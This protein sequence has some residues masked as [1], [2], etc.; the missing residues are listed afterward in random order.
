MEEMLN[1]ILPSDS[2]ETV[3]NLIFTTFDK[4]HNGNLNFVE[5]VTSLH[6]MSSSSPEVLTLSVY[7]SP[8]L[9]VCLSVS[10]SPCLSVCLPVCLPLS[11]SLCLSVCLSLSLRLRTS[12]TGCSSCTTVTAQAP[13]HCLRWCCCLPLSTR[14]RGSTTTWPW[15]ELRRYSVTSILTMTETSRRKSL[16]EDAYG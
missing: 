8:C 4:D 15:R 10:L 14:T 12:C 16:S 7:L 2:V 6:C 3:S 13:S 5:F 9:S 11:L 1:L